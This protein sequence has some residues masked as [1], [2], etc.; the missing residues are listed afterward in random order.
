MFPH[1]CPGTETRI[2]GAAIVHNWKLE[3]GGTG[4][5]AQAPIWLGCTLRPGQK[6]V[7][8]NKSTTFGEEREGR[9]TTVGQK[10]RCYF[11]PTE[12]LCPHSSLSDQ[13]REFIKAFNYFNYENK[14]IGE[15][16]AQSSFC[17]NIFLPSHALA[18]TLLWPIPILINLIWSD[19]LLCKNS[20]VKAR[21]MI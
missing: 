12:L 5:T 11:C 4:A 18:L 2:D 19:M 13:C 3:A 7:V 6:L 21:H 15:H 14:N 16:L 17:S 20:I 8:K 10:P 1:L 9:H